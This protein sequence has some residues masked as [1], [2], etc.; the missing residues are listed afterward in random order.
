MI[1][2]FPPWKH[3]AAA[4]DFVCNRPHGAMLAIP[5]A[6]GKT[7]VVVDLIQNSDA[8]RILIAAPLAVIPAWADEFGK[9]AVEREWQRLVILPLDEGP[10]RQRFE[11]AAFDMDMLGRDQRFIG[12]INYQAVWREPFRSW[13]LD[14]SWD[15]VVADE[16]HR[17]KSAG[18]KASWFFKTLSRRTGYRL[19]LSGTPMPH[20]P[21]DLYAQARFI[22]DSVFGTRKDAFL[23]RYCFLGG[24]SGRQIIG[25]QNMDELNQK[26]YSLAYRVPPDELDLPEEVDARRYTRLEPKAAKIYKELQ[27][28]FIVE[29]QRGTITAAN[30]AVKQ[31]RLQQIAGGWVR[32]TDKEY[33]HVSNAKLDLLEDLLTDA[34]ADEPLVIV[35]RFL[36]EIAAIHRVLRR[37]GRVHSG[38][39]S[40]S[41]NDLRAFQ[42]GRVRDLVV[43]IQAGSEGIDLTRSRLMIFYSPGVS[44][45]AYQQMRART[46]RPN[47]TA[48]KTRFMHLIVRGTE[49]E[50]TYRA[51]SNNMEIIEMVLQEET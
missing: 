38:E 8:K 33:H 5:M 15:L 35:C 7:K 16:S 49:D 14:Q 10:V 2:K 20:S 42:D 50:R 18:S 47:Q 39:L 48:K 34:P 37:M 27:K 13:A 40:G 22:D 44:L 28:E 6:G 4:Y 29:V 11:D 26:F 41:R 19:G 31:L 30:A 17:I 1:T 3:Q 21:L 12:V 36:P 43:Q 23:S 45:G 51:F 24:F 25:W 32:D 9:H 46:T